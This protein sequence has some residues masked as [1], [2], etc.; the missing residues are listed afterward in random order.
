MIVLN[1]SNR[2]RIF[3]LFLYTITGVFLWKI[4]AA[5]SLVGRKV[6]GF[7]GG[8]LGKLSTESPRLLLSDKGLAACAFS[9]ARFSSVIYAPTPTLEGE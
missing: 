5:C 6:T 9:I 7:L 4:Y 8:G 2:S 3:D 1:F